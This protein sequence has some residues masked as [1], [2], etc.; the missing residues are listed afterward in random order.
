MRPVT[1]ADD[2]VLLRPPGPEDAIAV[3]SA[4]QDPELQRWIAVPVPYLREH[5]EG[6]IDGAGELWAADGELRFTL[7][8][9]ADGSFA[10]AMSLHAREDGMREIGF[11]TAPW[12]RGRGLTTAGARLVCR[13]G[14]ETLGLRRIEW[15]ADVGNVGS[16]RVAQKAGFRLEGTLRGRIVH[17]GEV[18]DAWVAG[19]LP[20][21]LGIGSRRPDDVRLSTGRRS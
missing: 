14:F 5:A 20:E 19:L 3:E 21:D 11:W 10:G 8:D 17:R 6:W 4:C 2:R 15:L 18:R 1:L 12:A 13:W 16:R 7:A 9:R